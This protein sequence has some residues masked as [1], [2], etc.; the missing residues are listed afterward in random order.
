MELEQIIDTY[1]HI[2]SSEQAKLSKIKSKIFQIGSLRLAIVI[3][4]AFAIYF[5]WF[6]VPYILLSILVSSIV[7]LFLMKYHNHLFYKKQYYELQIENAENELKAIDYDFS[8]FDGGAEYIDGN[9]SFSLDLD[10]FGKR[11]FFQ[12]I[13]RTVTTYGKNELAR[14][15]LNPA[16]KKEEIIKN[17][18]I[19][20]EL[21]KKP[22]LLNH[23]R[24]VGQ[25]SDTQ[26]LDVKSFAERF[27]K[28]Q[29]LMNSW[30]RFAPFVPLATIFCFIL[31]FS[32]NFILCPI[33]SS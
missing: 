20:Q 4:C 31:L 33:S 10:L 21:A 16:D 27:E 1:K 6:N 29:P 8:P 24:A 18:N 26:H 13:N 30:W 11:S 3:A 25:M 19:I 14:R 2:I 7:F 28:S 15:F 17:Q 22:E 12:S 32:L 23:F 5:F 9:H